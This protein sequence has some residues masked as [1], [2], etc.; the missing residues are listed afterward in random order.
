MLSVCLAKFFRLYLSTLTA[1]DAIEIMVRIRLAATPTEAIM[2]DGT[3]SKPLIQLSRPQIEKE[4]QDRHGERKRDG[5]DNVQRL[6]CRQTEIVQTV[7]EH[8][9]EQHQPR[10]STR[11]FRQLS[12]DEPVSDHAGGSG[13]KKRC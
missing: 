10:L 8:G 4:Q 2:A 13:M 5:S 7:Y 3:E 12:F 6:S 9:Y 1:V 11:T